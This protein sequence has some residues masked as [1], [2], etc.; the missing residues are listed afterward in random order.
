MSEKH[1]KKELFETLL[2]LAIAAGSDEWVV[3]GLEHEL[4]LLAKRSAS[5]RPDAKK[6]AEQTAIK[7]GIAAVLG[8][9][10]EPMTATKIATALA[11]GTTVQRV[12]ALVG[13]MVK[14]GTVIREQDK[15]VVTFSLAL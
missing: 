6:V 1:T 2:V 9:T 5:K 8:A 7:D 15:K 14:D 12:T 13:Q 11:D 10:G 4:D 3:A